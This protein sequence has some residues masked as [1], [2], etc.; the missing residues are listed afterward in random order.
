LWK[1]FI[2]G[3]NGRLGTCDDVTLHQ[4]YMADVADSTRKAIDSV[5]ATRYF[6][7]YGENAWAAVKGY[8]DE[9]ASTAAAPVIEKY[10][11]VIA[12]A[13]V[14]AESHDLPGD[15]V[16]PARPR[17]RL[18]GAPLIASLPGTRPDRQPR[19]EPARRSGR[20]LTPRSQT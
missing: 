13:D 18:A 12:A 3:Y 17:P 4:Q 19:A 15:A 5:G 9:I 1:H 14:F 8:V 2:G 16:H 11:G 20:R 10:T 7:E 6:A